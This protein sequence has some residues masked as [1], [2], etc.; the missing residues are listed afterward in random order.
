MIGLGAMMHAARQ[1]LVARKTAGMETRFVVTQ[2]SNISLLSLELGLVRKRTTEP[3]TFVASAAIQCLKQGQKTATLHCQKRHRNS[4]PQCFAHP[5]AKHFLPLFL[6]LLPFRADYL[7]LAGTASA[8][9]DNHLSTGRAFALVTEPITRMITVRP[10]S[11][12]S[13]GASGYLVCARRP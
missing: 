11:I 2:S 3:G 10:R 13:E 12:T 8:R 7:D 6:H 1:Y 4:P 5:F 9:K